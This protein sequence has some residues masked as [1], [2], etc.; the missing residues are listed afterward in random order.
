[1]GGR[2]ERPTWLPAEELKGGAPLRSLAPLWRPP[3]GLFL[4]APSGSHYTPAHG[5]EVGVGAGAGRGSEGPVLRFQ[6]PTK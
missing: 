4:L 1:M 2:P 6:A 5:W 3:P